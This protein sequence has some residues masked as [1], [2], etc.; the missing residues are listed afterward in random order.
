MGI[1]HVSITSQNK[2]QYLELDKQ[3][4]VAFLQ[5]LHKNTQENLEHILTETVSST[6]VCIT[7]ECDMIKL[8]LY[9]IHLHVY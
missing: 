4:N 2:H 8:F 5:D 1:K 6:T 7:S 9:V 3:Y